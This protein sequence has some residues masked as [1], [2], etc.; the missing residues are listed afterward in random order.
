MALFL[1]HIE[2]VRSIDWGK[3]Y[4]WDILLPDAPPPFHKW[5]PATDV[6]EPLFNVESFNFDSSMGVHKIPLR[7]GGAPVMK[8][9]FLDNDRHA[10]SD[11]FEEWVD[12]QV[13]PKDRT[14]VNWVESAVKSI[15]IA[16]YDHTHSNIKTVNY[17]VYPEG[18]LGFHGSGESSSEPLVLDFVIVGKGKQKG[19][20][21]GVPPQMSTSLSSLIPNIPNVSGLFL[22]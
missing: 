1:K 10:L 15:M 16:K 3:A 9:T 14:T 22:T 11:F 5:F 19:S 18:E 17:W 20:V 6:E 21:G 8:I 2:Q 12:D 4:L 13:L 7:N